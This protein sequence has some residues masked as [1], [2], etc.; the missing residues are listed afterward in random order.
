MMPQQVFTLPPDACPKCGGSGHAILQTQGG[1]L[2]PGSIPPGSVFS[3]IRISHCDGCG[4]T[5]KVQ[6]LPTVV[7]QRTGTEDHQNERPEK[8]RGP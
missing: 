7:V 8:K 4:G 2:G 5:G 6:A 3:A 1:V